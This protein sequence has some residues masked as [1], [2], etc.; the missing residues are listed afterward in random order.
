MSYTKQNFTNGNVL[1]AE[2]LIALENGI[3]ELQDSLANLKVPTD[4]DTNSPIKYVESTDT[5]NLLNLRDFES[6]TYVLSGKFHPYA[7]ST[8]SISFASALLVNIIT[9]TAGT[10]VQVF[11]PV[12]NCVQFLNITDNSYERTNVYLNDLLTSIG[13]LSNLVTT[14]KTNLVGAI[15]ELAQNDGNGGNG[16]TLKVT[17]MWHDADCVVGTPSHSVTEIIEHWNKGGNVV[18]MPSSA[19]V[20]P[21]SE[22]SGSYVYFTSITVDGDS[23][24]KTEYELSGNNNT[25][26]KI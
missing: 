10:H 26:Y 3:L 12:N 18:L 25:I 19:T 17:V 6:G 14:E 20:V 24:V 23:I 2:Q 7:G 8:A 22:I 5:S 16:G 9:K 1:N 21:V 13:T 11:Y 15:N 4:S